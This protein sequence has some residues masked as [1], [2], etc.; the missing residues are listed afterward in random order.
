MLGTEVVAASAVALGF[1]GYLHDLTGAPVAL[2]AGLLIL[3]LS[4]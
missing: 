4:G 1:G 2:S 3:A